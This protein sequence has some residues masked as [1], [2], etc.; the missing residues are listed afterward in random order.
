[1]EHLPLPHGASLN[2]DDRAPYVA[3]PYDRGPFLSYPKRSRFKDLYALFTVDDELS[4]YVLPQSCDHLLPDLETFAQTWCFFGLLHAIFGD[5]VSEHMFI[6]YHQGSSAVLTTASLPAVIDNWLT[7]VRE[8]SVDLKERFEHYMTCITTIYMFLSGIEL[9][10]IVSQKIVLQTIAALA[11]TME[12]VIKYVSKGEWARASWFSL[13]APYGYLDAMARQGWSQQTIELLEKGEISGLSTFFYLAKVQ[14]R[15]QAPRLDSVQG[16]HSAHSPIASAV[17]LRHICPSRRCSDVST[18]VEAMHQILEHGNIALLDLSRYDPET[19][20]FVSVLSYEAGLQ[21]VAIS[22]VWAEGTGNERENAIPRCQLNYVAHIARQILHAQTERNLPL[23]VWFDTLCCPASSTRHKDMCLS[24]MHAIYQN[25]SHVLIVSSTLRHWNAAD[26]DPLEMSARLMASPWQTRLW[27]LQEGALACKLWIGLADQ[28]FDLDDIELSLKQA[29]ENRL[30]HRTIAL[31]FLWTL[32]GLRTLINTDRKIGQITQLEHLRNALRAREVTNPSDEPLCLATCLGLPQK[33]IVETRHEERMTEFW[34]VLNLSGHK[35]PRRIM[36]FSGPRL[37]YQGFRWSPSSLLQKH[38]LRW[39][40][41]ATADA[42]TLNPDGLRL[43][44]PGCSMSLTMPLAEENRTQM[45]RIFK[46]GDSYSNN[47]Q[48]TTQQQH[49]L[50][51]LVR[52]HEHGW[53]H[54]DEFTKVGRD[55]DTPTICQVL[56]EAKSSVTVIL[57]HELHNVP[58]SQQSR[59]TTGYLAGD[60]ESEGTDTIFLRP[61]VSGIVTKLNAT[62]STMYDAGWEVLEEMRRQETQ[63][64]PPSSS[65]PSSSSAKPGS[66]LAPRPDDAGYRQRLQHTSRRVSEAFTASGRALSESSVW[67]GA[68]RILAQ[69]GCVVEQD[70]GSEQKWCVP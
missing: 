42:A 36:F 35:I 60:M 9:R 70:F 57:T 28:P 56:R 54:L 53:F 24:Q 14:L 41:K 62:D 8:S 4:P 52:H 49:S 18:P 39:S 26:V 12:V 55:H 68:F 11:E 58:K 21:Y 15:H 32:L 34:R 7:S 61:L 19:S 29:C 6:D 40:V 47:Q 20:N 25:A 23:L 45:D 67:A 65:S 59:E 44:W 13:R 33:S 64:L 3:E 50:G 38:S 66:Y 69:E 51:M 2:A 1:M 46:R 22:H 27:T 10:R 31:S 37:P 16:S 30:C 43:S 17:S 63:F 5:D 48:R